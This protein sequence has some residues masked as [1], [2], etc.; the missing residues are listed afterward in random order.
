MK[1]MIQQLLRHREQGY[2]NSQALPFLVE[3]ITKVGMIQKD[4]SPLRCAA[5]CM[6]DESLKMTRTDDLH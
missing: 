3:S 6:A 1:S 2:D 4:S 5:S